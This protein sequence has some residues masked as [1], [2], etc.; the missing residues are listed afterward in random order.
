MLIF[1]FLLLLCIIAVLSRPGVI[2]LNL[3]THKAQDSI[4]NLIEQRALAL[5]L[6]IPMVVME[7][8]SMPFW[9]HMTESAVWMMMII[10]IGVPALA[11]PIAKA[12]K[13]VGF[14]D[15][16]AGLT[17]DKGRLL[18][19]L[20]ITIPYMASYEILM[21]GTLLHYLVARFD[22]AIAIAIN[23]AVYALMHIVKNRKEALLSFPLGALL[24]W[25]TIYTKSVWPAVVFH[26]LM[27]LSFEYYYSRKSQYVR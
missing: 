16:Y 17:G 9:F 10:L 8:S 21:R 22:V 2:R 15:F 3:L 13:S 14:R 1:L 4:D 7:L 23:A 18:I 24:C 26:T 6:M 5:I 20:V 12:D 27:A 19:Y 25:F 11:Y